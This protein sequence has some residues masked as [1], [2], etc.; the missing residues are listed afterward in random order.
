M[1]VLSKLN[2]SGNHKFTPGKTYIFCADDTPYYSDQQGDTEEIVDD[3]DNP[4]N[5]FFVWK[6]EDSPVE[7]PQPEPEPEAEPEAETIEPSLTPNWNPPIG[8]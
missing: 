4:S 3:L 6:V 8:R 5:N 7:P 1:I 2:T